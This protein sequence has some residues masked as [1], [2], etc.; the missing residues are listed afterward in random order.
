[1]NGGPRLSIGLPV[2]NGER[3][4][5]ESLDALL[6]QTFEDFELI[7]S[8]NASTDGTADIC[9]RYA[10]Q[11]SRIRYFRQARNI[12][13]A[14][15][16][17]FVFGQSRGE[18][19]C[20]TSADDLYARDLLKRCVD[21]LTEHPDAVLAAAWTAAV[22]GAGKLTQAL[23]YPLATEAASAP[24]R[25]RSMLFGAE[26]DYG[27]IRADDDY[28]VIRTDILRQVRP[29]NSYHHADKALMIELALRGRFHHERDWLYFRRDHSERAL[30][31]NPTVRSWC[32]NMD[33]RRAS[34]L[35]HPVARLYAEYLWGYVR[36]IQRAPLSPS[37]RRACYRYLMQWF[38]SRARRQGG[39]VADGE[40]LISAAANFSVDALVAGRQ[41]A[42][43]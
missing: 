12:G 32:T 29:H 24:Q 13:C 19:F 7:I 43:L 36:A 25:F 28:G 8:D 5:T 3:Y 18:F 37:D 16:H 39:T 11:D 26:E 1:V 10:E 27:L 42:A 40:P 30:H 23:E 38:A 4:L 41:E 6:G 9:R 15:N 35:R 22:D 14:P 31:A 34:R 20:W 21:A 2:Y 33:P 17:N